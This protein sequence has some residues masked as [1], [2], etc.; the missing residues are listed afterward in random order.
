VVHSAWPSPPAYQRIPGEIEPVEIEIALFEID[1]DPQALHIVV[2]TAPAPDA[3]VQRILS[4]MAEGRMAEIMG[5]RQCLGQIFVE[6]E[7]PGEAARNLGDFQRVGQ[8]C[9]VVV[10]LL[11]HDDLGF[12]RQAPERGGVQDAV[13]VALE[14]AAMG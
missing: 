6:A 13:A 5:Q 12:Q 9:A 2:E 7:R 14:V 10:A 8:P 1:D 3:M 11:G 4:R